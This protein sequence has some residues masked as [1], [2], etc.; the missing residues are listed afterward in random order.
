MKK[1][2]FSMLLCVAMV[3]SLA[4]GCGTK[5]EEAP[6]ETT[7]EVVKVTLGTQVQ[8]EE[9]FKTIEEEFEAKGYELE[10]QIFDDVNT[11]NIALEEG[12]ID[13]N[14][15]Q[16]TP[17]MNSFNESNDGHLAALEP[18]LMHSVYALYSEKYDSLEEL[19]DG[20]TIGIPGDPSNQSCN[21]EVLAS[22]GVIT[23]KELDEG[24]LHSI[25]DIVENPHNYEFVEA[26]LASIPGLY[27]DCDAVLSAAISFAKAEI[28]Y[29]NPLA[30]NQDY[31]QYP[32]IVAVH[33]DNA[34][35]QWAKDLMEVLT[36]D[37]M[38]D[39]INE[40]MSGTFISIF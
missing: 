20:A 30:V 22:A 23:L 10:I 26:E 31:T 35:A 7:A 32:M 24:E 33:E 19:P 13:A 9:V 39:V 12:S 37:K 11:P 36:Q 18:G 4:V 5:T 38:R 40:C 17:F 29:S 21:L 25:Y 14:F 34:D 16:H 6:E 28:D 27:P 3:A 15:F 2:L 1:R 8:Y